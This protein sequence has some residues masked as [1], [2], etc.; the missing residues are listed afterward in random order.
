[1]L[2][3]VVKSLE[4]ITSKGQRK[5]LEASDCKPGTI[6]IK[7]FRNITASDL[8]MLLPRV[9]VVMSFADLVSVSTTGANPRK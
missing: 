9:R 8:Y 4:E 6:L 2:V 7:Y 5:R 3:L 1:M